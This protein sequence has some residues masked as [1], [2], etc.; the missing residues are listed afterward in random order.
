[1]EIL[2]I[3]FP[4]LYD[5]IIYLTANMWQ[6]LISLQ[7]INLNLTAEVMLIKIKLKFLEH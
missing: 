6:K 2:E 3:L 1:M 7:A 5:L 4:A